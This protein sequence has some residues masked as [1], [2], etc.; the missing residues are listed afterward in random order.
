[1]LV[2]TRA[3]A[4]ISAK[5]CEPKERAPRLGRRAGREACP[6]KKKAAPALP[7]H[8]PAPELLQMH[9]LVPREAARDSLFR[10]RSRAGVRLLVRHIP[11]ET[12]QA[13][14]RAHRNSQYPNCE[15]LQRALRLAKADPLAT[16]SNTVLL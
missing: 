14:P 11:R 8:R 6:A 13:K 7:R 15:A 2:Q 12:A 10:W 5:W 1:M 4:Q 16:S 9:A 3:A